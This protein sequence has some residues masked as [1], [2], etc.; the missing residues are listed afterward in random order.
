MHSYKCMMYIYL[1]SSFVGR[2]N[3]PVALTDD[4]WMLATSNGVHKP[5]GVVIIHHVEESPSAPWHSL[6]QSLPEMVECN[7]HLHHLVC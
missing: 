1:F 3:E 2:S 5:V 6:H 4:S 7:R